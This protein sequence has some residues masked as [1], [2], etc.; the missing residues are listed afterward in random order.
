MAQMLIAEVVEEAAAHGGGVQRGREQSKTPQILWTGSCRRVSP[1]PPPVPLA[2]LPL[3]PCSLLLQPPPVSPVHPLGFSGAE[4]T[5]IH[6][7]TSKA[8]PVPPATGQHPL[9]K[10]RVTNTCAGNN[11]ISPGCFKVKDHV[12]E[13]RD[14]SYKNSSSTCRG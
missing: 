13:S 4:V 12:S 2:G 3:P 6:Q 9:P 1:S 14:V 10:G 8:P 5:A 7:T 11:R